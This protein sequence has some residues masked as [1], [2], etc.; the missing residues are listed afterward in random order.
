VVTRALRNQLIVAV[1][2]AADLVVLG[3]LLSPAVE[4]TRFRNALIA[5]VGAAAEFDWTP[6]NPPPD[7]LLESAS[8]PSPF[9][10]VG[11]ALSARAYDAEGLAIAII[12]HMHAHP[13]SKGRIQSSTLEAYEAIRATGTGYCADYTQVFNALA[14]AA[15]LPVREWGMSFDK[16]DGSGHAFSEIFDRRSGRWIFVDPFNGLLV[17][18]RS[19]GRALSVLEFRQRLIDDEL[20]RID[21]ADVGSRH[22]FDSAR[23]V[24]EYYR[25]GADEFFLWFGNNVFTYDQS[26]VIAP[27]RVWRPLEQLVGI[28]L[29]IHPEIRILPTPTNQRDIADLLAFRWYV[30]VCIG[31]AVVLGIVLAVSLARRLRLRG[32]LAAT[33]PSRGDQRRK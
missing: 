4:M 17:R 23:E 11:D 10:E 30:I 29:G 25:K 13:K 20:D 31:A 6:S 28:S 33:S 16:F 19:T 3:A 14:L 24:L 18:D 15:R 32:H 12:E 2:L 8:P 5:E 1:L 7:F 9:A 22:R 27:F 21:V 26:P